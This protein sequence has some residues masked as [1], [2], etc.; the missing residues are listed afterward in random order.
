[1]R[2]SLLLFLRDPT[3]ILLAQ[4]PTDGACLLRSQVQWKVPFVLVEYAQL[5][6]LVGVDDCQHFGD[7]FAKVMSVEGHA[8]LV[9]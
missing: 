5:M 9:I 4:S 8:L 7:G 3:S 6:P 1:M 2:L